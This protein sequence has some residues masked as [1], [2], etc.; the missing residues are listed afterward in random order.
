MKLKHPSLVSQGSLNR[1][2]EA[3]NESWKRCDFQTAIETM[4]RASRLNPSNAGILLD[5]GRMYG[6]RH[7]YAA[8]ERCFEKAIHIAPQKTEVLSAAGFQ[9]RDFGNFVMAENYY[10]RAIQQK[11][12]TPEIIVQLAKLYERLRRT[13]DAA[14]MVEK[15]L[16]LNNACP[17]ALL[18]RARLER[19]AG[20]LNEAEQLI[21]S[22]LG[23]KNAD[24][25]V[26]AQ[27]WYEL[28][29]ILDRQGRYDDAMSTFL[30]AKALLRPNASPLFDQ[31]QLSRKHLKQMQ[32]D[33][34]AEMLQRW[35]NSATHLQ[36]FHRLTLLGG[37]PRSGTT[38]LEQVLDSHPDIVSVEE[39]TIFH[40]DA[41]VPLQHSFPS[42]TAILSFL[43]LAQTETL[44]QSRANYFR[45]VEKFLGNS[46]GERLLIDKNPSLTFLIPPLI[47]IFPEIKL[48][49]ALRD[50]RDVVLSCFMQSIQLGQVSSAYLS[51]ENTINEYVAMMSLWQTIAPM[52]KGHY[53]EVRYEDMVD[54]LESV[55]RKSLDFLGVAWN[56]RVLGFDEHARQKVVRSPTYADVTQ[57]VYKRAR[58]RWRNYQK[59]LEPY[60]EKLELFVKAFGYE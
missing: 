43:E 4:E 17:E 18:T 48:L 49:I 30:E 38:L 26:Y 19:Q 42:E 51:L 46:I 55:A 28:G 2:F 29:G 24:T 39:T 25:W 40:D 44:Q 13:K 22:F 54:D 52:V 32:N 11:N 12:V 8:A 58:G 59:Y 31:L 37:H 15:A 57:P 1:I 16:K 20:H 53:L 60:L 45:S 7:D 47:R 10:L 14:D 34:S 21:R 50:P 3:V 23:K 41:Y 36:S 6:L 56:A 35:F 27:A 33:I 9:S 5:L